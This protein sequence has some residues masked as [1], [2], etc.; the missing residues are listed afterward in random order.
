MKVSAILYLKNALYCKVVHKNYNRIFQRKVL[1][2]SWIT[3]FAFG[4]IYILINIRKRMY[5]MKFYLRK[6]L[7]LGKNP[8]KSNNIQS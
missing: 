4:E 2:V 7:A 1:N 5:S 6:N 8:I 3:A